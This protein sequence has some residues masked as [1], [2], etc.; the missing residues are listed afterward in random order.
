MEVTMDSVMSKIGN[1][2]I[3]ALAGMLVGV[4]AILGGIS[5]AIVKV[6]SSNRRQMQLD[7]M[8]A[9]LKLEMIQRGMSAE[10]I[11]AVLKARTGSNQNWNFNLNGGMYGC[12]KRPEFAKQH[13]NI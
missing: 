5:V 11:A 6:V 4:I 7:E 2:E 12:R 13:E 8:D 3:L 1:E 9:S 10:E